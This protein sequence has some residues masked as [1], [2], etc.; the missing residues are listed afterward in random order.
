MIYFRKIAFNLILFLNILLVFLSLF[1][2][3]VEVPVFLQVSGRLHP[4]IVHFPL[5]LLFIVIFFE[6]LGFRKK[7]RLSLNPEVIEYLLYFFALSAALGA[8]FGFFLFL[9]G[10]YQEDQINLH[11][12]TG[13]AISLLSVLLLVLN[14][15]S[16]SFYYATLTLTVICVI[17]TGHV[18]SEVTHGKGFVM[19]PIRR[20]QQ[21]IEIEHPDSAIV[22][23]DVIQ[24]ILNEK[25]VSCHSAGKAKNDLILTDYKNIMKG[26]EQPGTI[27]SGNAE[28]SLLYKYIM[29]PMSDT[30]HMP[31][32]GKMQL[33]REEIKLIGWWINSG[34]SEH[35]KYL[36]MEK[37]D[38]I[39]SIMVTKFQPK[40][41]LDLI[42]IP[43]ADPA[44][45]KSLT[46]PYRN[47]SQISAVK[48]YVSVFLGGKKD[49]KFDDLAE[50]NS[51][52]KQVVSIDLGNSTV[53]EADMKALSEFPHLQKLHLQNI[54][55]GDGGLQYLRNLRFLE[56]LNLSGT[57]ITGKALNEISGWKNLKKLYIYNTSVDQA[58]VESLKKVNPELQVYSTQLDLTDSLYYAKLTLPV[59]KIDSQFF[60][61][62]A[63]VDVKPS[64][65]KVK[66]YYTLDGSSPTVQSSLYT[67][68]L[69]VDQTATLRIISTMSGWVASDV[70]THHLVKVGKTASIIQFQ[71]KPDLK[72]SAKSDSVLF[73]GHPGSPD[74]N[75]KAY[76]VFTTHDF[77][78]IFQ[79]K[80]AVKLSQISLSFLQD[81]D[82]G[83]F[84]PDG[85]EVWGGLERNQMAS[86]GVFSQSEMQIKSAEKGLVI[87]NF[88]QREIRFFRLKAKNI[89]ALPSN[90]PLSEKGKAML[91][92][93]EI[94]IN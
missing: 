75:D 42:D 64:R 62:R 81:V 36:Q 39:Q 9:E 85:I 56:V 43:F 91:Y 57:N 37:V 93:D 50:L 19:E 76:L 2:D 88:P 13:T 68:P 58:S 66:Y 24:P 7:N 89:G 51:I 54:S 77:D 14:K 40:K 35:K 67:E 38:S 3:K 59:V 21:R 31:P 20:Q 45:I 82:Q 6:W 90:H 5:V 32:E 72:L 44:R 4:A 86:L 18:G 69:Q 34:S 52:S 70:A 25:C 78:A 60:R 92:I 49:F 46:N 47:V 87:I 33:D 8:L 79:T 17:I 55:I 29:L 27:V 83:I 53:T 63:I 65:G 84:P 23:R 94:A 1:E 74:R 71:K 26:G 41:G 30:L 48:P 28:R 22:F 10:G 80:A 61:G 12:W 16:S 11:R 73:D 15:K